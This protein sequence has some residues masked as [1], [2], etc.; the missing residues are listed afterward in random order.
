MQ[1][2]LSR[3]KKNRSVPFFT[4]FIALALL[5]CA[6]LRR[7]TE[8]LQ[9][10]IG[11]LFP[12][13][14]GTTWVYE[15][16]DAAGRSAR[17]RARVS[18][19]VDLGADG[20]K[21]TLVEENGGVPGER[22][23][24]GDADLVAYTTLGGLI[25]RFPWPSPRIETAKASASRGEPVLPEDPERRPVWRGS[26]PILAIE[27]PPLYDAQSESHVASWDEAVDV[28]AGRF[29]RCLRVETKVLARPPSSPTEIVHHYVEWYAHGVGLVKMQSSV[30]VDGR[31][32]D[33]LGADLA[34]FDRSAR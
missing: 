11:A 21:A 22:N 27:G 2:V 10:S 29:E 33:V 17:L 13:S 23:L 28:P 9:P 4:F 25:M 8:S 20:T 15:V 3:S 6:T 18:G 14:P 34:S 26:Y 12:L 16:H 1:S 31:R 19:E 5:G 7:P 24:E 30:D 32:L